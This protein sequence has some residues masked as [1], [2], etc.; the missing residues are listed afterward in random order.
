M[1]S[2]RSDQVIFLIDF[3]AI[4]IETTFCITKHEERKKAIVMS[5]SNV[6]DTLEGYKINE[7]EMPLGFQIQVGKQ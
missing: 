4:I 2:A 5:Y 6:D 1:R 7:T 3:R